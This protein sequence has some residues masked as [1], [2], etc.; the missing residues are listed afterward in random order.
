MSIVI[1]SDPKTDPRE[2]IKM[3]TRANLTKLAYK[4]HNVLT[5]AERKKWYTAARQL[6]CLDQMG[7]PVKMT[8]FNYYLKKGGI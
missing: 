7:K 5:T 4:W 3:T 2:R 6:S 1:F 8:G